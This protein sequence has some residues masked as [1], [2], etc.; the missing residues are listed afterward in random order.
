M[1]NSAGRFVW[2]EL[3][4]TDMTAAKAF[5]AKVL[6]WTVH[7]A[8]MAGGSYSL[9][10]TAGAPA[11][12][13]M[14]LP[15]EA[16]RMGA[17]PYWL[18]YVRVDDV[19]VA[20]A[21]FEKSG[22]TVHVPPTDV[23][24]IGR[25]SVVSDPQMATLALVK[26]AEPPQEQQQPSAPGHA[27]WHELFASNRETAF[28]FYSAVFGWAKA[29]SA[30]TTENYQPF[31]AGDDVIGGMLDKPDSLP[32]SFWL[33]YFTVDDVEKAIERV[34]AGGGQ[35]LYGPAAL[36]AG[37]RIAHCRDPQGALFALLDRRRPVSFSMT[38]GR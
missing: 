3:M 35:I 20:A 16:R 11:A 9:F 29:E 28:S 12:G 36:P 14:K 30:G 32:I 21:Q 7:D 27:A 37:G 8:P 5:Y 4:T 13:L 15:E 33:Y 24:G 25:F 10:N 18:G 19:D 38:A 34:K 2:H 22:G 26:G 6:G 1:V 31:S 23:P 17:I